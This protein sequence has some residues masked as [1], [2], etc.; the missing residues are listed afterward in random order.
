MNQADFE[1]HMSQHPIRL[2]IVRATKGSSK[3]GINKINV[4]TDIDWAYYR[5]TVPGRRFFMRGPERRGKQPTP[6]EAICGLTL[7]SKKKRLTTGMFGAEILG[8][9]GD[10]QQSLPDEHNDHA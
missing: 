8:G 7:K 6:T 2:Q 5:P 4:D 10:D 9:T 1:R 3:C